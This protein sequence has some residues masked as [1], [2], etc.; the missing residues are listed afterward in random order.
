MS[1]IRLPGGRK[2]S[3]VRGVMVAQPRQNYYRIALETA[4]GIKVEAKAYDSQPLLDLARQMSRMG[5]DMTVMERVSGRL[6]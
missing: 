1:E 3:L 5:Y 6:P 4:E 2:A